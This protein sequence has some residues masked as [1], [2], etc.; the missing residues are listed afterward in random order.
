MPW[1]DT[2]RTGWDAIRSHR[3]RSGLT[4]LG[5]LI[6]IAAVVLTVGLGEGAQDKVSSQIS[7]LGSNLLLISPGSSTDSGGVRGGLGSS[8]TLTVE[9]ATALSSKVNAP[10]VAAVAPTSQRSEALTAG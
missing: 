3:L 6:G 9:D 2:L 10:D 8:S 4:T 1:L 5:I 7:A